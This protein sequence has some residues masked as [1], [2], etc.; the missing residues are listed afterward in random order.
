MMEVRGNFLI[1]EADNL[2]ASIPN[3]QVSA[4]WSLSVML[5]LEDD[6]LDNALFRTTEKKLQ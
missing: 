4:A 3:V 5:S 2:P 6:D 1:T